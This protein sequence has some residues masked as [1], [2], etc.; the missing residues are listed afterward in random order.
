[1]VVYGFTSNRKLLA[2]ARK[3]KQSSSGTSDLE[4]ES[5]DLRNHRKANTGSKMNSNFSSNEESSDFFINKYQT[6]AINKAG[7]T[8]YDVQF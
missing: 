1:M 2:T 4:F 5:K 7:S 3:Q 8:V 6:R